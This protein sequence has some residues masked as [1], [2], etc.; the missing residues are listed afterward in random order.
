VA[1]LP[2]VEIVVGLVVLGYLVGLP[3]LLLTLEDGRG[4]SRRVWAACGQRRSRWEQRLFV[5]Y[6]LGGWPVVV[7]AVSWRQGRLRHELRRERAFER[8]RGHY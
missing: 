1:D 2:K 6:A 4:I 7:L 3:V 5:S 8:D